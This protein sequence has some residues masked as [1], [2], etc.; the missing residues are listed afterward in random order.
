MVE[1]EKIWS[2]VLHERTPSREAKSSRV[3][4]DVDGGDMLS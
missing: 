3:M 4:N 2:R 1:Y